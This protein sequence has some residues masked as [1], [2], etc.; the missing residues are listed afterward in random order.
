LQGFW[1]KTNL[2]API[3]LHLPKPSTFNLSFELAE[4]RGPH[5]STLERAPAVEGLEPYV[6]CA[7]LIHP[8]DDGDPV[9]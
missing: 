4:L 3:I 6:Y 9:G 8:F 2:S 7:T 1:G 5:L